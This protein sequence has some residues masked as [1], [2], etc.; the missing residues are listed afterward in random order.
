MILKTNKGDREF[1]GADPYLEWGTSAPPPPGSV[2]NQVG[3]MPVTDESAMKIAAVYGSVSVIADSV[4]S[5]P[6]RVL[7]APST[8]TTAQ[9]LPLP[10][11][12]QRPY[13]PISQVDWLAQVVWSLALKGNFIGKIL[14]RDPTTGLPTQI[15]PIPV[16][17]VSVYRDNKNGM[18]W[19]F[20]GEVQNP[21]DIFIIRQQT[22][23]GQILGLSPI[24]FMA[25]S[26]GLA[27][28]ADLASGEA[29]RNGANPQ[30]VIQVPEELDEDEAKKLKAGWLSAN[31]GLRNTGLPAVLTGGAIFNAVQ[32][33]SQ[34]LQLLESKKWSQEEISGIIFRVPPFMLGMTERST[35]FGRGIEQQELSF[36]R[37]CLQGYLWR[38]EEAL[39][40]CLP[41]HQF[42]NFDIRPR[43]Q[44]TGL[45]RA[46]QVSLMSLS[47]VYL[48]DDA[49]SVMG[50][51]PL[52]NGEGKV[53]FTPANAQLL[54]EK[55]KELEA[56]QA[57]APQLQLLPPVNQ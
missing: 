22:I 57:P 46:Q 56:E 3:G 16:D 55:L 34:D 48:I 23:P 50:L 17:I 2:G 40:A 19:R 54:E 45:E 30:G 14:E 8:L 33:S 41:E 12:L 10:E 26:F 43:I 39:T 32:M 51:P 25:N 6:L 13:E 38:I 44:G 1:R 11:L 27:T 49:R 7:N 29:F 4:I 15:C 31:G 5:L 42:A 20:A 36:V 28:A 52:P 53:S 47:G 18:I 21:A 35:S 24:K 37:G 9:E